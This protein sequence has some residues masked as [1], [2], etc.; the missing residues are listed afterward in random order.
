[1]KMT[2]LIVSIF[3]IILL[4][5]SC[6]K[7]WEEHYNTPP[8]TVDKNIWEVIQGT[9]SI[10][11]FIGYMQEFKMDTLFNKNAAYTIFIPT[12][13]AVDDFIAGDS[14]TE[15]LILNHIS[16]HFVQSG[17]IK[18]SAKIQMLTEKYVLFEHF[19]NTSLFDGIPLETESPLYRNGKFYVM[20]QVSLPKP[21][22]FEYYSIS[23][24]V[25]KDYILSLDSIVLDKEKSRPI[26]FDDLGRTVYDTVSEIY[27]EFEDEYF[28][29]REEFRYKTATIVFPKTED[30]NLALDDMANELGPLYQDHADIPI[31]WQNEIL[32][33]YLLDH[34]VFE[35]SLSEIDFVKTG[36]PS[37]TLKLKNILGDSIAI[38]Y[39]V[40]D[41]YICS[42]GV[43]F[44]YKH[45]TIPDTLYNSA[46][47]FEGESF[48]YETGVNKFNW[49]AE[50]TD[51]ITDKT[52]NIFAD[53]IPTA[54]NDSI[55]RIMLESGYTGSYKVTLYLKNLFPRK[56][57]MVVRTN[58]LYGGKYNLYMNNQLIER[59]ETS[60]P[61]YDYTIDYYEYY[62]AGTRW[63][64]P[65]V[66]GDR[67]FYDPKTPGYVVFDAFVES[68]APYGEAKLTF[69]YMGESDL[70]PN[71]ALLLDYIDFI[72]YDF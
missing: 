15:S 38:E 53:S 10:S 46:T 60:R 59:N 8:P 2:R 52:F 16:Q 37:D 3:V 54:S 57:L 22:L 61:S 40:S 5:P 14:I 62:T 12:N 4:I 19:N 58:K 50:V 66:T 27:N 24:P 7:E 17:S 41:K 56:Y 32:I 30:Y 47:R 31:D 49:D 36:A 71:V 6:M 13:E 63:Y 21:N 72:P 26:G 65:S 45:F 44:N 28:P 70:V 33:P 18:G 29:V 42:N 69:E 20:N 34:G 11:K 55:C 39:Q 43:S 64:F 9:D 68:T 67:Y 25:L 48:L 23:N 35:N 51:V 1:M